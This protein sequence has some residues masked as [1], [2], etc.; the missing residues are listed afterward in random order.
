MRKAHEKKKSEVAAGGEDQFWLEP[1]AYLLEEIA[2]SGAELPPPKISD[3]AWLV[4]PGG[5]WRRVDERSLRKLST[6][7]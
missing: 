3:P 2:S 5:A 7:L 6:F 4:P 1:H